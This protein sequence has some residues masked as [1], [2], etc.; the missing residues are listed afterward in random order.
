[1]SE[2]VKALQGLFE[3]L[4]SE[5]S[6]FKDRVEAIE[7]TMA[8]LRSSIVLP[9]VKLFPIQKDHETFTFKEEKSE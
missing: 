9:P 4:Y 5:V 8:H 1:M 6:K 3:N 7:E 2:H